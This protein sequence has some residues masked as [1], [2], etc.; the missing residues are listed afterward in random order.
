MRFS[1]SGTVFLLSFFLVSIAHLHAQGRAAF[2][3]FNISDRLAALSHLRYCPIEENPVCPI[4][5]A[6]FLDPHKNQSHIDYTR[7][8]YSS[9]YIDAQSVQPLPP[10][11]VLKPADAYEEARKLQHL[12]RLSVPHAKTYT[13]SQNDQWI[14]L[15]RHEMGKSGI[16]I[17]RP[18]IVIVVDRNPTIQSLCFILALPGGYPWQVLGG[19]QVSTGKKGRKLYYITP[20]GAF[21]NTTERVGYRALGTKNRLGIRGNGGK[22]MRVWDFGWQW[23][24]KGWLPNHVKGQ[25][26]LEMHAT[27]PVYL[28]PRL[29][30]T[31]SEGCIRISAAMNRF[32]DHYGL[33]DALYNQAAS[34]EKRFRAILLKDRQP[35]PLAGDLLIVVDSSEKR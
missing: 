8:E 26:R 24:E 16:Q 30:H 25:I 6:Q 31:A 3:S 19:E 35:S 1:V 28:E 32:I 29:G 14:S 13:H 2:T 10:L 34:Q 5:Y 27:D 22:G 21:M 4:D 9:L 17:K 33:I 12:L 20:V 23:A 15:A 7:L 18:Q 11:P